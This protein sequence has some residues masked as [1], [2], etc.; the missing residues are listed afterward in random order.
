MA[1]TL[2]EAALEM[3]PLSDTRQDLG[4]SQE[5]NCEFV[6]VFEDPR[7][8]RVRQPRQASR[9]HALDRE[10]GNAQPHDIDRHHA[11]EARRRRCD[12]VRRYTATTPTTSR[13]RNVIRIK[14]LR[15]TIQPPLFERS[16]HEVFLCLRTLKTPG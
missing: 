7:Y 12:A 11:G 14:P 3:L 1:K 2:R 16:S 6:S 5:E 15:R 4:A 13:A 10:R 8:R 9:C